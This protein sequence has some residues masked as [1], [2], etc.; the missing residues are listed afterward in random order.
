MQILFA[1]I[2]TEFTRLRAQMEGILIHSSEFCQEYSPEKQPGKDSSA[3]LR[4]A[5]FGLRLLAKVE[6]WRV[7][8]NFGRQP[9]S[10]FFEI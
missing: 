7:V 6:I 4:S 9:R 1:V 10:T 2:I 8:A 3:T 5:F